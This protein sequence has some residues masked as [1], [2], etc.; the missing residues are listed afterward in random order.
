MDDLKFSCLHIIKYILNTYGW[1]TN[2]LVQLSDFLKGWHKRE[3]HN[4]IA[5]PLVPNSR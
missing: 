5:Q 4:I 1:L 3:D 2:G